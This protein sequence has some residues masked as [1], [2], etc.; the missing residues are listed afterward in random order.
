MFKLPEKI[1]QNEEEEVEKLPVAELSTTKKA[2][3]RKE[4]DT[5]NMDVD[6]GFFFKCESYFQEKEETKETEKEDEGNDENEQEMSIEEEEFEILSNPARVTRR[7]LKFISY[8]VDTRYKPIAEGVHGV[9]LLK[10]TKPEEDENIIQ[11]GVPSLEVT[12]DFE[13]EPEAPEPFTF[14]G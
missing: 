7:Q 10:D 8:D 13:D 6:E 4:K 3:K 9:I 14:L 2:K 5:D 1:K 11:P 12:D